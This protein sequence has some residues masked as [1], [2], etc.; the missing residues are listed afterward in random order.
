MTAHKSWSK[1][2]SAP[3]PSEPTREKSAAPRPDATFARLEARA[4]A[5]EGQAREREA[6]RQ[7]RREANAAL[8]EADP[9]RAAA[10]R[11]RGSGRRDIVRE[12]RDTSGYAMVV[13][14]EK[15]RA[16]AR[17]GASTTS[18]AAVFDV[19]IDEIMR[20]LAQED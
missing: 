15:I 7:S 19:P 12:Q 1:P 16:L 13:D 6:M 17:R 20:V 4:A 3:A 2:P 10:A 18:L 9:H 8:A 5:R 14:A 11:H